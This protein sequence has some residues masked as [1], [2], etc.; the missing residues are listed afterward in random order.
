[1]P[2]ATSPW[3]WIHADFAEIK[4]QQFL[5]VVDSHSKWLEVVPVTS[6]TSQSTI[7][8]LRSLFARFGLPMQLVSDNG[9]QF[10][11]EEFKTFLHM[12]D[13]DRLLFPPYHPASNG[14]AEKYVQTFMQMYAKLGKMPLQ[15]KVSKILFAYRNTAHSVTGVSPAELFLKRAPRTLL[16]LVKPDMGRRVARSQTLNG[17]KIAGRWSK[18]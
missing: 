10:T 2:W 14:Q 3:Q 7:T 18:C 11:S 1:M 13:I 8:V 9:P 16:S 5:L 4:G 12:N 15:E 6:T 17:C